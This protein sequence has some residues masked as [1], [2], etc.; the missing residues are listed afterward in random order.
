MGRRRRLDAL[1]CKLLALPVERLVIGILV[2]QDHCQQARPGK[3]ACDCVKRRLRLRYRL[4]RPAAEL[5]S[6]MLG[7]EPLPRDHVERLG[8]V[9]ANLA[10]F[11]A[12][13]MDTRS[14]PGERCAGAANRQRVA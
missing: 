1:A 8:D 11:A 4:A 10:K 3:A 13:R 6:H 14:A 5:L 9:L 12:A 7:H 2:D